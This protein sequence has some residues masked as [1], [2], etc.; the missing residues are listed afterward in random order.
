MKIAILGFGTVG[1][2]VYEILQRKETNDTAQLEAAHI[3]I[4]KGKEKTLSVMTDDLDVILEDPEC[5]C[6]VEVMGGIEPAHTYILK[7]L[8]K[9][10][11]VVTANKAVVAAHLEEFLET[12]RPT[13]SSI[14][15]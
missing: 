11:H 3:F 9:G 12:A 8:R 15:W 13:T 2:G 10:K 1:R 7:A 6:V 4:R 5:R 14:R